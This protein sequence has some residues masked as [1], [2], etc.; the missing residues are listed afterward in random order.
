MAQDS[1]DRQGGCGKP[2]SVVAPS[3]LAVHGNGEEAVAAS[4]PSVPE[5][6]DRASSPVASHSGILPA[7]ASDLGVG[8]RR[9][10]PKTQRNAR[11]GAA[12][13]AAVMRWS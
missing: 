12:A 8:V 10:G 3:L 5:H 4:M 13:G 1:S 11:G 2:T 7:F 9:G 6:R